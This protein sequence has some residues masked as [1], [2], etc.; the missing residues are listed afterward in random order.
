M[1]HK[2]TGVA[3]NAKSYSVTSHKIVQSSYLW[4]TS[5][6]VEVHFKDSLS[7]EANLINFNHQE[8]L[9]CLLAIYAPFHL[10]LNC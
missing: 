6:I 8:R 7:T 10:H 4:Q 9:V 1:K 2:N 5:L 3:E